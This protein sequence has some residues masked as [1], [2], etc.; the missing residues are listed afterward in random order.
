M[1]NKNCAYYDGGSVGETPFSL[2]L[3]LLPSKNTGDADPN[4]KMQILGL[5]G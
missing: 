2:V 5:K 4:H 3:M 1:K